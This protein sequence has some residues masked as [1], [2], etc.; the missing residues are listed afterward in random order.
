MTKNIYFLRK[1]KKLYYDSNVI[2]R[3]CTYFIRSL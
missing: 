2:E 3:A 1:Q